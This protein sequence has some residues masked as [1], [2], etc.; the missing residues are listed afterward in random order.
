MPKKHGPNFS[1]GLFCATG[2]HFMSSGMK[3]FWVLVCVHKVNSYSPKTISTCKDSKFKCLFII[4]EVAYQSLFYFILSPLKWSG[5]CKLARINLQNQ[6]L[7][8]KKDLLAFHS[9][10]AGFLKTSTTLLM[11]KQT[12]NNQKIKSSTSKSSEFFSHTPPL[13]LYYVILWGEKKTTDFYP[14][15]MRRPIKITATFPDFRK[16]L[17]STNAAHNL[18]LW[19]KQTTKCPNFEP[20]MQNEPRN[21]KQMVILRSFFLM[22]LHLKGKRRRQILRAQDQWIKTSPRS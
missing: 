13:D 9:H 19:S 6:K 1:C 17:I 2:K 12:K 22:R 7:P 16:I 15:W 10:V 3:L 4:E 5:T 21:K 8:R 20:L 11:L 14:A 18:F